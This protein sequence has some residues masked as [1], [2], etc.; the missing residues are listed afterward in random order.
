MPQSAEE[1]PPTVT[2]YT[3]LVLISLLVALV[4]PFWLRGPDGQPVMTADDLGVSPAAVGELAAKARNLVSPAPAEGDSAADGPA[5]AADGGYYR[6]QDDNGVWHFSDQS[7]EHLEAT[8]QPL[9]EPANRIAPP[10][11]VAAVSP[12][13]GGN[14]P[15]I[16]SS[17]DLPLPAGVSRE[18]IETLLEDA[19]QRRM[20]DQR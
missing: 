13:G 12:E 14:P 16:D 8:L 17:I 3:R 19:H 6:W 20:G 18:A 11:P 2:W 5:T 9:P 10:E 7:P 1:N 15:E 4:L